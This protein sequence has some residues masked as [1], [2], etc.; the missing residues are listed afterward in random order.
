MPRT[1]PKVIAVTGLV[2]ATAFLATHRPGYFSTPRYLGGI[3]V[4]EF[5]ALVVFNYREAFFPVLIVVFVLAGSI[6]PGHEL[7][8]S[9]RWVVL[10]VGALAGLVLWFR[11]PRQSLG[12]FHLLAFGC[13]VS[14]GVSAAVSAYPEEALLKAL[15][16]FLLFAY[17]AA[18]A[19]VAVIA[20]EEK[21]FSTLLVGAEG[22]VYISAVAYFGLRWELFGNRNSLGVVMGVIALPV[23]LW[24]F[25]ISEAS[26]TR[27]RRMAALLLCIVLLLCSY[28]RAG[29]VA[30]AISSALLCLGLRRYRLL[31][32][33]TAIALL[34]APVV[35]TFVPLPA[36]TPSDV[37]SVAT[38][39]IYKGKRD[40]G[41]L[42]SRET[43]W[44]ATLS[45]LRQHPWLGTGFGTSATAY[46]KTEIAQT[47]SSATQASR[48]HGN[49]YLEILD[50]VG[51]LGAIPFFIL[52]SFVLIRVT[53]V[54]LWMRRF[55]CPYSPA[56][57]LAVFAAGALV[58]AGFE[59]WLF[60]VGY[61]TCILFWTF[62][63]LLND[64]VSYS[65]RALVARPEPSVRDEVPP[66]V[67]VV[68]QACTSF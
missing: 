50:W 36:A 32:A 14:A 22:L 55:R 65:T 37:D 18:G 16:L 19:R 38:R 31:I 30:G 66:M 42:A 60:A 33:G 49:S 61:H 68:A 10:S 46:D 5:L 62:A 12:V 17:G 57:P 11:M 28:E 58:H 2:A 52:L 53:R 35:T 24:G 63:F 51:V 64:F 13:V 43:V 44:Q 27:H 20:R 45:S 7:W 54:V 40:A 4:F 23:L 9:A 47:F 48:E 21:F 1:W 26:F 6:V 39:F 67:D 41:I 59:D 8:I 56:V 3:I 15:S 25:I 34:A 29:I